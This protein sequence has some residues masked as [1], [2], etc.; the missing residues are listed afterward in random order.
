[1]YSY[2][3]FVY[4][5]AVSIT[6]KQLEKKQVKYLARILQYLSNLI[7]FF[8]LPKANKGAGVGRI[9]CGDFVGEHLLTL[10]TEQQGHSGDIRSAYCARIRSCM[11]LRLYNI[12]SRYISIL[13]MCT[14]CMHVCVRVLYR[15]VST[16]PM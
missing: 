8:G 9:G 2:S 14:L 1:M 15:Y 11:L 5:T 7:A 3:A 12:M 10:F 6:R 13:H 4:E 16:A